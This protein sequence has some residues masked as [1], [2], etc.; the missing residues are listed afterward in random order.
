MYVELAIL[1]VFVLLYSAVAGGL[2]KTP[3][4]GPIV[5]T[6][7]GLIAGPVGLGFLDL[8]VDKEGL[9]FIAELTLA[10]VLFIDASNADLDELER[11]VHIPR[12]MLLIGLPLTILLGYWAGLLLF[13][14]LGVFELALLAVM[15]APTDAAL[16]K[17]VVNNKAVP[18]SIRES[19]NAESGLNDGICVPFLYLFLALA[20]GAYAETD[21]LGLTL[22]L[23]AKEIGIGLV[24][25]LGLTALG[26]WVLKLCYR[27]QWIT[28]IW[29]QL[30]VIALAIGCFATAQALHG[31]GFV[32]AFVGGLLFAYMAR[33]DKKGKHKLLHAA[34]GTAETL[35]LLT[36][37]IFGAVVVGQSVEYFSWQII[38]YAILSLT[39]IRMLPVFLSL[40]GLGMNTE[41]KLFLGWFGPRG[42]ASIVFILI[43]LKVH[44]PEEESG[45]LAVTVVC[46]VLLSI[47]A[48]GVTA[49]PL[50]SAFAARVRQREGDSAPGA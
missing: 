44:L 21:T 9:Q 40:T 50:A 38:V 35:A 45:T 11:F 15:L 26:A 8:D 30:P 1:A 19:L 10:L 24:V 36:W 29:I 14:G 25:G 39:V 4:S 18:S 12:R 34:E 6:L 22:Y 2:E 49:N 3:I 37:V 47:L 42:L 20:V 31:S 32:A 13:D 17:P 48:H 5:F 28:E 46:T 16:G 7:F 27:R 41:S 33:R 43:V 23:F